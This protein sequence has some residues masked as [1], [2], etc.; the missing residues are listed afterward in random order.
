MADQE[1]ESAAAEWA[2]V[3]SERE[4]PTE[5][6]APA[7]AAEP[8]VKLEDAPATAEAPKEEVDPYAGFHPDVRAKLER[9]DQMATAQQQLLNDLKEAK[10]RI[11]A[12]QSEFA[13][14]RQAKPAE[15][16]SQAQIAAATVNPEKWESLKKDF[17]EW[18]EG[19]TAFV[20][21]RLGQ[22][23]TGVEQE[24][25]EQLLAQRTEETST[26]LA[27]LE[28]KYNEA[29][30]S[31][32]HKDWRKEVN[33][34]EFHAWFQVQAPDVQSLAASP[35][36]LDAIDMLDRFH[37]DRARSPAAVRQ[38]R[39]ERLRAA[40]T[41]KPGPAKV[42]KTFE[43]MSPAEQWQYLAQEREKAQG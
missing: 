22:L 41:T 24:A 26:Q 10:G 28:K 21:A 27:Q 14:S 6:A 43:E 9:F 30:V 32:K 12:L 15:Q 40:V 42:T 8:E 11:G 37:A 4:G 36:G 5:N 3:Q 7:A 13:K 38:E 29:L 33:S 16:P 31:V 23:K 34:P 2:A 35:N 1:L 19:I 18:G 39:T 25:V 17:P 20:E